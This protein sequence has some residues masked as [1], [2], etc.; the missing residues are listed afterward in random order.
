MKVKLLKTGEYLYNKNL[1]QLILVQICP[2]F[3]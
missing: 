1:K 3:S 2:L